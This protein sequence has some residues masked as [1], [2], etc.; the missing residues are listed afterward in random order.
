MSGS[1]MKTCPPQ[2][3]AGGP[4]KHGGHDFSEPYEQ[5][6]EY[7]GWEGG[8]RCSKCGLRNMDFDLL[9]LP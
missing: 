8:Y 5:K 2:C 9:R 4:E 7:G 1:I 6:N 3:D